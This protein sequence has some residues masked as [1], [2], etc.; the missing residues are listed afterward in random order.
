MGGMAQ[1][2][3]RSALLRH[4]QRASAFFLREAVAAEV[5]ERLA[6]VN[7]RFAAPAVVTPFPQVWADRLP[8]ARFVADDETLD[9]KTGAHDLVVHDLCLHWANDPVGQLVQAGRAL[10]PDGLLLATTF[11]GSTLAE[12]R[13]VLTEAEV[14]ATG[15]LSPRVAPMGEIR[16]LGNLLGRVG[17]ALPVADSMPFDV[18]Y[19]DALA[20][21]RDLRAMG[22][23][24]ALLGRV[25]RFT[26]RSV[27]GGAMARY[28][29]RD[30]RAV[31]H[32]EVVTLSAWA[33]A[34]N[35]PKALRPGSAVRSLGDALE[36][37]RRESEG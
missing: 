2:T 34:P 16:D 14:E 1:I 22:E 8:H 17:L 33:P 30:G 32:F 4:R 12:L 35:Q 7:R 36:Q 26:R 24:N 20:L 5:Q 25:R 21:M 13:A 15:G 31:A 19:P 11:G 23:A 18:S 9:L 37:A 6:E 27:I 10:A 3:D 28:P 29:V